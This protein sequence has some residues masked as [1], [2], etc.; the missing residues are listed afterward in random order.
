MTDYDLLTAQ[1]EALLESESGYLPFL[2]NLSALIKDSME[3]VNWAGFYLLRGGFLVVGPFQGHPAC[4]RIEIGK[5]VC[6]TAV[7][8]MRNR[9]PAGQDAGGSGCTRV[10]R[11]YRLRRR[12]RFGDCGSAPRRR[13]KDPGRSGYRQSFKGPFYGNGSGRPGETV[14]PAER[15]NLLGS[16]RAGSF[17]LKEGFH[18]GLCDYRPPVIHSSFF[19]AGAS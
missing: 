3:D 6:G 7:K 12:F 9:H 13:W 18:P 4:I 1:A 14:R 5:G 10:S 16:V 17:S 8:E 11:A 15:E 19:I 2:S